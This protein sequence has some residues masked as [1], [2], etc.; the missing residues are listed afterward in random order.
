MICTEPANLLNCYQL[1]AGLGKGLEKDFML[2]GNS[3]TWNDTMLTLFP[4]LAPTM[5]M[6]GCAA[7]LIERMTV[8]QIT[9]MKTII[10]LTRI[11]SS[12]KTS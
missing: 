6:F 10:I 4:V 11:T 9:V 5:A 1:R 8:N 7:H 2:V 12:Q 3:S